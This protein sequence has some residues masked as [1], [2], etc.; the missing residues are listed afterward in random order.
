VGSTVEQKQVI[1]Y[2]GSTGLSTGPHVDFRIRKDDRY[3]NPAT[4]RTPPGD[5]IPPEQRPEF[6]ATRDALLAELDPT[7]VASLGEAL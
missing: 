7:P 4:L 3:V 5:P 6:F 1:G 2:V